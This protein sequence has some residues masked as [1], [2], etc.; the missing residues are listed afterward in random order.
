MSLIQCLSSIGLAAVTLSTL[1]AEPRCPKN[2]DSL[3]LRVVQSSLIVVP[4]RINQTGPYDFLVDTGAQV[5]TVDSSLASD[6]RLESEGTTG[7]DGVVTHAR[8]TFAYLDLV[9]AGTHSVAD[10]LAVIED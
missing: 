2:V 3:T 5:T 8:D 4:V 10:S 6:L 9:Q 7:V 1:Y